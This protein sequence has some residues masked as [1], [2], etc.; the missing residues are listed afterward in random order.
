MSMHEANCLDCFLLVSREVVVPILSIPDADG[1]VVA[2]SQQDI[3]VF[4]DA[5]HGV[6]VTHHG[7]EVLACL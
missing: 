2:S 7:A 6:F 3:T 4:S 5:C 1:H